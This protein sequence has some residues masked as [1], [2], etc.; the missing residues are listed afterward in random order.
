MTDEN[1]EDGYQQADPYAERK[2]LTF[3]QAEGIEPLPR[4]LQPK[5]ISQQLRALLWA[6]IY[7]EIRGCV[8]SDAFSSNILTGRWLAISKRHFLFH[9]LGMVDE[10]NSSATQ[11]IQEIK[12]VIRHG[13]F[14]EL[15]GLVQF[16]IRCRECSQE[17]KI[18][19][20]RTLEFCRSAYRVYDGDTIVPIASM[21]DVE[22]LQTAFA[23][24]ASSEFH[25]ARTHLR[26]AGE[27]ATAGRYTDSIRE[28][29]HAVESVAKALAPKANTLD[30]AI[31]RLERAGVIHT[32]LKK[33]FSNIYGYTNDQQGIRHALLDDPCAKVDETDALFMLGA[34]ASF[35]SYLIGKGRSAGILKRNALDDS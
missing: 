25:G 13:D 9:K 10:F 5:E 20:N 21:A 16:I 8:R 29:I 3:A 12:T 32:S 7:D 22:P 35:V 23:D 30:A 15:L 24:L 1:H 11:F 2:K 26:Q 34:C 33:G 19:I 28:S 4:Q 27:H 18:A 14:S 6:V 31:A 17:L